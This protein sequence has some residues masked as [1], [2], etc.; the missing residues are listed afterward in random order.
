MDNKV[1]HMRAQA[2]LALVFTECRRRVSEVLRKA[3]GDEVQA[4]VEYFDNP[5]GREAVGALAGRTA[6]HLM[7]LMGIT[8]TEPCA[9]QS[10][11]PG[12][13]IVVE[14][15]DGHYW[16]MEGDRELMKAADR[17]EAVAQCWAHAILHRDP[18]GFS[19]RGSEVRQWQD[20]YVGRLYA[21]CADEVSARRL[22]W[23]AWTRRTQEGMPQP[24]ALAWSDEEVEEFEAHE[25][26]LQ[27]ELDARTEEVLSQT[28]AYEGS[29]VETASVAV[30]PAAP[31]CDEPGS[32]ASPK[33]PDETTTQ[34]L[35]RMER[36]GAE[37][38]DDAPQHTDP[39]TR[40]AVCN[41]TEAAICRTLPRM[42]NASEVK[43][44][45]VV[46]FGAAVVVRLLD[47][48][49]YGCF[50]TGYH[51]AIG[52]PWWL[53]AEVELLAEN[54]TESQIAEVAGLFPAEAERWCEGFR[55]AKAG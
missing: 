29:G 34:W 23:R 46:K 51:P 19:V 28:M 4:A 48:R 11:P 22:A 9:D 54:L 27:R 33:H 36:E 20:S 53:A 49:H 21:S 41:E 31:D 39:E 7:H 5:G 32:W 47:G 1:F 43:P 6:V 12:G 17:T 26:D 24:D 10:R 45:S 50:G 2:M 15:A 25:A 16:G 40:A 52:S 35:E 18:P 42:V 44:G 37:R 8:P 14:R 55:G 30:P 3:P 38:S 13:Y